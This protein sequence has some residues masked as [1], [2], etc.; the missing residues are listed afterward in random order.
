MIGE[1]GADDAWQVK[2]MVMAFERMQRGPRKRPVRKPRPR[3]AGVSLDDLTFHAGRVR[4]AMEGA[5]LEPT[6]RLL[7][8]GTSPFPRGWCKVSSFLLGFYLHDL[9]QIPGVTLVK[10]VNGE[11]HDEETLTSSSH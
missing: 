8:S 10:Y 7:A 2:R 1:Q 11:R 5:A 6:L 3:F 9:A 4:R